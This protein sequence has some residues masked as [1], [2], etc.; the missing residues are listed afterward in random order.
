[1]KAINKFLKKNPP[2]EVEV[3]TARGGRE[4]CLLLSNRLAILDHKKRWF[5]HLSYVGNHTSSTFIPDKHVAFLDELFKID[6]V[7]DAALEPDRFM[8]EITYESEGIKPHKFVIYIDGE[9]VYST[10]SG[11]KCNRM[12]DEYIHEQKVGNMSFNHLKVVDPDNEKVDFL[13][14]QHDPNVAKARQAAKAVRD[15]LNI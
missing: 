12:R 6:D 4:T 3:E 10:T 11:S 5:Y 13:F 8:D 14:N 7:I 15:A 2:M 1:M 9:E